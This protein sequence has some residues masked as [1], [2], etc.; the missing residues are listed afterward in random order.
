[1]VHPTA[2]FGQRGVPRGALTFL[3]EDGW[4]ET[5]NLLLVTTPGDS[6]NLGFEQGP[7]TAEGCL[8]GR[9]LGVFTSLGAGGVAIAGQ[10][11]TLS[12]RIADDC[13][14]PLDTGPVSAVFSS[15]DAPLPLSNVG[16]G[17]WEATWTPAVAGQTAVSLNVA[18][19]GGSD[20]VAQA[21]LQ[22]NAAA[23]P[24]LPVI[25]RRG[26]E[27]SKTRRGTEADRGA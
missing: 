24:A 11:F 9:F 14:V 26:G 10:P 16:N 15:G 27:S 4:I 18:A 3:F 5:V 23:G 21:N 12:A 2:A 19:A 22:V 25:F 17:D 7:R 8:P 6:G 1:M 20:A 13:G